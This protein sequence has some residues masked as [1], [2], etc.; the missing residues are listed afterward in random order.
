MVD[1]ALT[2]SLDTDTSKAQSKISTF[3]G[4]TQQKFTKMLSSVSAGLQVASVATFAGLVLAMVG[5]TAA[6]VKFENE[7]AN[8]KKTMNDVKD[9]QVFKAIEKDLLNLAQQIPVMAGELAGIAAVGGQLGVGAQDIARFTEV[10]A[11]LGTATNMTA[12]QAA[13]S[14]A[15]F[16]NVTNESTDQIGKYAAVLVELGNSTAATEGEI[17]MLAQ[18]FGATG[19][20]AGLS[21]EEIL[22]FS[23]AMRETGQ[24]SQA[25]ATALTK[26]FRGLSDAAKIGGQEMAVFAETAGMD[27]HEFRRLIETDIGEAATIFLG[28][29]NDMGASGQSTTAILDELGLGTERVSRAILSLANNEEGLADARARAIKQA[30]TQNALNDEAAQKFETAAM[31]IQQIKAALNAAAI[32]LGQ[33]FLPVFKVFLEFILGVV[34]ALQGLAELFNEFPA[35]FVALTVGTGSV[36]LAM[37]TAASEV[38][39]FSAAIGNAAKAVTKFSIIATVV[40][41]AF[42]MMGK[43]YKKF[44]EDIA[45]TETI[46]DATTDILDKIRIDLTNGFKA[47]PIQKEDWADFLQ[48][49][50]EATR[51][52]VEFGVKQ[53][54]LGADVFD[55]LVSGAKDLPPEFTQLFADVIDLDEGFF[56][57]GD[58]DVVEVQKMLKMIE[59]SGNSSLDPLKAT[60]QEYLSLITKSDKA[61]REQRDTLMEVLKVQFGIVDGVQEELAVRNKEISK[62]LND[63]FGILVKTDKRI[64]DM[65][66]TEEGRLKLARDL[67]KQGLQ[68]F[69]DLL[70]DANEEADALAEN[71]EQVESNIDVLVRMANDFRSKVDNLFAPLQEQFEM[72]QNEMDLV[73]AH[74]THAKLHEE[75]QDLTQED[76]DLQKELADLGDA[77]LR[78]HEE[79]LE[80]QELENEAVEIEKRLREDMA[81]S[82]NDQLR[83]EKLKKELARV[84]AAAAQGSLEFADLEKK[85][86]EEQIA[87][88]DA[89]ALTQKDADDKRAEASK[90][91]QSAEERRLE[92]INEVEERRIE[93]GERLKEIPRDIKEAHFDIH[94]LQRDLVNNQLDLIE[95]QAKYNTMKEDELRMTAELLGMNMTQIDGLMTLMNHNR[96]ESSIFGQGYIDQLIGNLPQLMSL[97]GYG[98]GNSATGPQAADL[99]RDWNYSGGSFANMKPTYRHAGGSFMPGKNYVVGEY[100][101]ETLKAFPGG[102]GM[103]TP[104]DGGSR[105]GTV[106]N[107]TLNVTGLPSDPIAARRTAQLIQKELNKLKGDGRSGIVR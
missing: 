23:A 47:D 71:F 65:M 40:V 61:S 89:K 87:E 98:T 94:K 2:S 55:A 104:M 51:D 90:I 52:A 25:G 63:H 70:G 81:L 36:A 4:Q 9:P 27:V 3:L 69:V 8:V 107:V 19:T 11:K 59:D 100:G 84:N 21:T 50:P 7:F 15:R 28:G 82:A 62:E 80:M 33:T 88:I 30:V 35:L 95:A 12:E 64:R 44:K 48:N 74:E 106:N 10:V 45:D 67:A 96:V 1:Y 93:I 26:L 37:K 38:T 49:L 79:K 6:A 66:S 78:T 72:Q 101:P 54:F 14:M 32:T 42:V 39:T 56:G 91:A 57:R 22:A 13:T 34:A 16:L 68:P 97:L 86:I 77:D 17:I 18:N 75:Q 76:L 83:K 5:G 31:Q 85:A 105:G 60:L 73:K 24:Q 41:G 99:I 58:L 46:M 103:I 29:I 43:A 53:G 102:G 92:R 20:L